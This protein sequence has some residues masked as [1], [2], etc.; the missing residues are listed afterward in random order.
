LPCCKISHVDTVIDGTCRSARCQDLG[1]HA[2]GR[3]S[4]SCWNDAMTI[5]W[6]DSGAEGGITRYVTT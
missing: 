4:G 1:T 3:R 2:H 5:C 6:I